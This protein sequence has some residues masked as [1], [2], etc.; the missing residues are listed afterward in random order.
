VHRWL[1]RHRRVHFHFTPTYASWLNLVERFFGL[2]TQKAL[3]RGS[4]TSISQLRAAILAASRR[5]TNG[6]HPS[7]GS[8][9]PTRFS[10]TCAGSVSACS[11]CMANDYTCPKNHRSRGLD[12]MDTIALAGK[13]VG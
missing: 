4:H 5:I 13:C 7:S 11:G 10:T 8:R 6:A 2:L 3:K 12:M 1:L 9:A